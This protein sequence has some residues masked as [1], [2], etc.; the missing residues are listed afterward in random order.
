VESTHP[1][2]KSVAAG[3]FKVDIYV[4]VETIHRASPVYSHSSVTCHRASTMP[5]YTKMAIHRA[6]PVYSHFSILGHRA[7]HKLISGVGRGTAPSP[8]P[9][10]VVRRV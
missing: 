8:D 4:W 7:T 1:P 3:L 5:K 9:T 6:S 2:W 10:P